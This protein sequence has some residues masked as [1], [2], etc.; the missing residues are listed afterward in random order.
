[1]KTITGMYRDQFRAVEDAAESWKADYDEATGV[2]ELEEVIRP[3][4]KDCTT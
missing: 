4:A 2:H 1:M 3:H